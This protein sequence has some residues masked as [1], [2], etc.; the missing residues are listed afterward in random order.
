MADVQ[1]EIERL[2]QQYFIDWIKKDIPVSQMQTVYKYGQKGWDDYCIYCALIPNSKVQEAL[3]DSSWDFRVDQGEPGNVIYGPSTC[4]SV[5]F[6]SP[7]KIR[8]RF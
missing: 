4:S 2:E 1:K 7:C 5:A 8:T 3:K 6:V